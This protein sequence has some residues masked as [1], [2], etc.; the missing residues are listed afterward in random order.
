MPTSE[1]EII[2]TGELARQLGVSK[3]TIWRWTRDGILPPSRKLG[4]RAV[5]YLRS[6]VEACDRLAELYLHKNISWE[7]V[8]LADV[9]KAISAL[10]ER[11][12]RPTRCSNE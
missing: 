7:I 3:V 11:K 2:R 4:T 9:R 8:S 6:E 10:N 5:G 12:A 1:I